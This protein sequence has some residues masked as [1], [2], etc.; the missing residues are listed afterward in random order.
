MFHTTW[1]QPAFGRSRVVYNLTIMKV[2]SITLENES[3]LWERRPRRDVGVAPTSIPLT[4]M[5]K[6]LV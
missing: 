1:L 5:V 3:D 6:P 4:F 2:L